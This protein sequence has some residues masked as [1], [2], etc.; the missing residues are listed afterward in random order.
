MQGRRLVQGSWEARLH[1]CRTEPSQGGRLG[2][3]TGRG[4]SDVPASL[5]AAASSPGIISMALWLSAFSGLNNKLS[6]YSSER[7]ADE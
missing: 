7:A 2:N 5:P 6:P 1:L 4:C 3:C